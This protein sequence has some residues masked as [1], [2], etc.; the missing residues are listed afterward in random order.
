MFN[1]SRRHF[2]KLSAAVGVAS[3]LVLPAQAKDANG[4]I[5]VA[6]LGMGG[7]G[8]Y[9]ARSYAEA[10]GA[11][12]A[13]VA[14]ADW[15]RASSSA[16]KLGEKYKIE[17]AA[18]QDARK[19]L[20]D[21]NIDAISIATCN[22]WHA[23]W[24]VWACQAG[25]HVY[26][27]K[28]CCHTM[29]EG[30][31][32]IEAAAKYKVCVQHGTQRRHSDGWRKAAA[33]FQS[34]KYG[35]PV[36]V[37]AFAHRPRVGIGFRSETTPPEWIDW[38][39]WVGPS[40][41][42]PYHG[43]LTP[44]NWHWFWNTG[45]GE[46]GNNGVHHFDM[47]RLGMNDPHR[48]PNRVLAFG[49]RFINDPKAGYKDQAET[50]NVQMAIYDYDGFPC[51]FESC[52]L[53]SKN[54]TP[55]ETAWFHTTEG[56]VTEGRFYPKN[57][58]P[59]ALECDDF[60][61]VNPGGQFGNFLNCVRDNTP[62]KLNA[63]MTEAHYSTALCHL[64]NISERLGRPTSWDACVS[65]MGDNPIV[66][67]RMELL[68]N[69]MRDVLEGVDVKKEVPFVLGEAISIDNATE[70][71]PGNDRANAMLTKP[72]RAPFVMPKTV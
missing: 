72:D 27:E 34:G 50:P 28:P 18:V 61:P 60:T 47:C 9:H 65:A 70:Q 41:M 49:T 3:P 59:V 30:R 23:L 55:Y 13:A 52:N 39:L 21:P 53:R 1:V 64:G 10:E 40:A 38:N 66:Q 12:L 22:H 29:F 43:N 58:D 11:T 7:Q 63:P 42:V 2:L 69:N 15:R 33:A 26:V 5:R 71:F 57:G 17:V 68:L 54:W 45:N 25:K 14:D 32:L 4:K 20:D 62:E 8:N 36:A 56:Y 44:Y 67:E 48:H 46:I 16:E 35:K 51:I 37:H 6:V 24:A 19:L 31:K